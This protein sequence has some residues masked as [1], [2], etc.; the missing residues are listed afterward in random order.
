MEQM[1]RENIDTSELRAQAGTEMEDFRAS[2]RT[3]LDKRE[4]AECPS[5][6]G[7]TVQVG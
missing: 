3:M 4:I 7:R 6:Y 2:I 5:H 1:E